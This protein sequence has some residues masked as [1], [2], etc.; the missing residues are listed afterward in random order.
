METV[1]IQYSGPTIYDHSCHGATT[2]ICGYN[3]GGGGV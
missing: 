3:I 1:T 2:L